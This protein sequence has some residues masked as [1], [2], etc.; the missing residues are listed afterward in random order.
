[1]VFYIL[2]S[3]WALNSFSSNCSFVVESCSIHIFFVHIPKDEAKSE[4]SFHILLLYELA[5]RSFLSFLVVSPEFY[6][7]LHI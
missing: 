5:F 1:M 2:C 4:R 7:C 6:F 3:T